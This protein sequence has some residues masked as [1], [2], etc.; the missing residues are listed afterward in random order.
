MVTH[1]R[2]IAWVLHRGNLNSL[3]HI[4]NIQKYYFSKYLHPR[5][6]KEPQAPALLRVK[7]FLMFYARKISGSK[8][9]TLTELLVVIS[10]IG[11]LSST[12]LAA[13]NSVRVKAD[14][15]AR[16]EV[17]A[18]Y[19]KAAYLILDE[20]GTGPS[21]GDFCLGNHPGGTCIV[22]DNPNVISAVV[23]QAFAKYI[24]GLPIFKPIFDST[25]KRYDSPTYS[26][27]PFSPPC[28]VM[29][30]FWYMD[31]ENQICI[32]GSLSVS[33]AGITACWLQIR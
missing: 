22:A 32:G 26:C 21:P 8:G 28:N 3:K 13:V 9:F 1:L 16:L 29:N 2:R 11:L 27:V 25:G 15:A 17:V 5:P 6:H 31:G 14:N 30:L 4:L 18:E 12:V 33:W 19:Q 7:N 24:P 23:N 20:T 10:I